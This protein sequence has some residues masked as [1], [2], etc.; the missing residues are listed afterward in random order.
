M[1]EHINSIST[2]PFFIG[3]MMLLL[4]IGSRFITHELS[5]DDKEYS[6]NILL[7]RLA[8]FAACFVGTRDVIV[9]VILTAAFVILAGGFL[10]GKG[11]FSKEG[12]TSGPP[13]D[14]A[15]RAAAGLAGQVDA[16]AYDNE[17]KSMFS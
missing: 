7:R 11:P 9:S 10:R 16:P 8:I 13:P 4:N 2:S 5:H 12:M 3:V 14:L 1:L 6:Q 17:K 15:I